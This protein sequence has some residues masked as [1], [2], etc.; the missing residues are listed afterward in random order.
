MNFNERVSEEILHIKERKFRVF[1]HEFCYAVLTGRRNHHKGKN[2][3]NTNRLTTLRKEACGW[4]FDT[5]WIKLYSLK[6]TTVTFN[7]QLQVVILVWIPKG[8]PWHA[9]VRFYILHLNVSKGKDH[10]TRLW[11][12]TP[13]S[14]HT[15]IIS[16]IYNRLG[17]VFIAAVKISLL[18]SKQERI[19][20]KEKHPSYTPYTIGNSSRVIFKTTD[21]KGIRQQPL[22]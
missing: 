22:T 15:P 8:C 13:Y 7:S 14:I 18:D 4:D 1:C 5:H 3:T 16:L 6:T 17:T 21:P 11:L 2:S 19:K 20:G 10:S 9:E 12:S